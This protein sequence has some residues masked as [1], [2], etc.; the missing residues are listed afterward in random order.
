MTVTTEQGTSA[1]VPTDQYTVG[2]VIQL[3]SP[4]GG[5]TAGGT[6]VTLL[7]A[8]FGGAT[9]VGF[10]ATTVTSGIVV[11]TNGSSLTVASP[12]LSVGVYAIGFE[13]GGSLV[14]KA[15]ET[16]DRTSITINAITYEA[17]VYYSSSST[18]YAIAKPNQIVNIEEDGQCLKMTIPQT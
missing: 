12:A 8:N 14:V 13:N 9:A 4:A 1:I 15:Q 18:N 17:K 6:S 16:S 7:G 11:N 2:P 3:V 10:G 5:S